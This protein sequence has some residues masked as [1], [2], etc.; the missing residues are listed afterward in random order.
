MYVEAMT[1]K[2]AKKTANAMSKILDKVEEEQDRRPRYVQAD[3]V[4]EF[5]GDYAKLLSDL[6][7]EKR[8]TLDGQSQSNGLVERANGKLKQISLKIK[9][10]LKSHGS[11]I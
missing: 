3:D 1:G 5:K 7:I 6:K 9:R 2:T 11:R 8:R 10:Y 4:S